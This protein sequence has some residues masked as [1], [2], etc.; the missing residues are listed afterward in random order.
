[1]W[2]FLCIRVQF[3]E[4]IHWRMKIAFVVMKALKCLM[5]GSE[6]CNDFSNNI[7]DLL[8]LVVTKTDGWLTRGYTAQ[9]TGHWQQTAH[10]LSQTIRAWSLIAEWAVAKRVR[11]MSWI[12]NI[13]WL[14][15]DV[16]FRNGFFFQE[17]VHFAVGL[18]TWHCINI[19]T[20]LVTNTKRQ[21]APQRRTA[22][23][24]LARKMIP[25]TT[26][27]NT[28]KLELYRAHDPVCNMYISD[29]STVNQKW[30]ISLK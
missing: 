9:V 14:I 2:R 29:C 13:S 25:T 27:K 16:V 6:T 10:S 24:R 11:F 23:N 28:K 4:N 22:G 3:L 15:A 20:S 5:L 30:V 17:F 12:S 18:Y 26:K 21:S 1:M 8:S 19:L 7:V